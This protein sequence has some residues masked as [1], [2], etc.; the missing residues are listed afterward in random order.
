MT[1]N[2]HDITTVSLKRDT[3][4]RLAA[5]R[6]AYGDTFDSVICRL[7]NLKE[8]VEGVKK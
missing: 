4:T 3:Y 8:S 2:S 6:T 1:D 5:E 7:L